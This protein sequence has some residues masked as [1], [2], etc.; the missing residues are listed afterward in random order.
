MKPQKPTDRLSYSGDLK[1]VMQEICRAY[2]LGSLRN[3]SPVEIGYED[4]NI[5]VETSEGK[6]LAKM[7]SK[8]RSADDVR[9]YAAIMQ[10][11]AESGVSHPE[12][13]QD[14]NKQT[15]SKV[16]GI[17]LVVMRFIEGKTFFELNRAPDEHERKAVVEQAVKINLIKYHPSY[18]FD[19]WAI[20]NIRAMYDKV[21]RFIQPEDLKL[22]DRAIQ[23]YEAIRTADL[24]QCFVHGDFT[25]TNVLKGND[26]TI[27]ILDFSV[28]NWYPRIQELA[29][30]A[31]NLLY[32]TVPGHSLKR[33]CEAVANDYGALAKLTDLERASLYPYAL[34]GVAME[35][36]GAH[37]ER[38]ING[39]DTKETDYWLTLGR[40]G[41]KEALG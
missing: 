22:V 4:C 2:S 11:V 6:F 13:F 34:A 29:V 35:F 41:L 18:L 15:L 5:F 24:P 19:S 27:Y 30:I 3:F 39:N 31:A 12:L 25:K 37:Q 40:T 36:M 14:Q 23:K 7:F 26:G 9:R 28:S 21:A 8:L 16:S 10:Q 38:Y 32:D 17:P 1:P 20:T 33:A